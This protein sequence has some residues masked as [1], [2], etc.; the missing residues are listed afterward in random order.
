M[1]VVEEALEEHVRM[2]GGGDQITH[3]KLEQHF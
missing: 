3:L 2:E 1:T